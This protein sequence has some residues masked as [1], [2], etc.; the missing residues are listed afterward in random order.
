MLPMMDRTRFTGSVLALALVA[1]A[2]GAE[3][4]TGPPA[5]R[6]GDKAP[7]FRLPSAQKGATVSLQSFR[8]RPVLLYFSM[9]PG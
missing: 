5:L 2:C 3:P 9:G 1:M 6:E 7:A 8:G 4:K